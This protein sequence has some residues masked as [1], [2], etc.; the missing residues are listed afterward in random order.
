MKVQLNA[1]TAMVM[2]LALH[3]Y[4]DAMYKQAHT[5]RTGNGHHLTREEA[6][7]AAATCDTR[8][9]VALELLHELDEA[10]ARADQSTLP[11]AYLASM[12]P[13]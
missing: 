12:G 5:F 1:G 6:L 3:D 11:T 8:S 4:V 2:R 7:L 13:N 9:K 10:E